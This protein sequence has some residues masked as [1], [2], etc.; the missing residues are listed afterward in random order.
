M[1][2]LYRS[3]VFKSKSRFNKGK[4]VISDPC[5]IK[6]EVSYSE[7]AVQSIARDNNIS[8]ESHEILFSNTGSEILTVL[9]EKTKDCFEFYF[10]FVAL[11]VPGEFRTQTVDYYYIKES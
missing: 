8:T 11:V 2:Q 6:D 1:S 3:F 9:K 5:L 7:T 4:I 10:E